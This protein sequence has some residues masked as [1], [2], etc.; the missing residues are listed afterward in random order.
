MEYLFGKKIRSLREARGLLQRQVAYHLD[1]DSP[2]LSNIERG[3]RRAKRE[4]IPKLAKLLQ[5]SE[6]ELLTY[7]L[8]DRVFDVVDNE[9]VAKETIKTVAKS[10]GLKAV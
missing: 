4:W 3:D 1:I 2:M 8:A 6:E 7:W 5:V 9:K 10:I